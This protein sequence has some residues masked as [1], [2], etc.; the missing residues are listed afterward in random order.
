MT[1]YHSVTTLSQRDTLSHCYIFSIK[2]FVSYFLSLGY[3]DTWL[4]SMNILLAKEYIKWIA[5]SQL[6][7]INRFVTLMSRIRIG[8]SNVLRL[9]LKFAAR[10]SCVAGC[11]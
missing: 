5:Y 4:W 6:K 7:P 8:Y 9:V 11:L 10:L 1:P 2:L 3:V